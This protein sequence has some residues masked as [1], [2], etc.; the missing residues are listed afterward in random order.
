VLDRFDPIIFWSN[1]ALEAH[2]RD[3]TFDG[4][5]RRDE[6]GK[7]RTEL[8]PV[9]GGPT[10]TSRAFAIIHLAMY[11]AMFRVDPDAFRAKHSAFAELACYQA[12]LPSAP[13][14]ASKAAAVAGAA[15]VTIRILFNDNLVEEMLTRFRLHLLENGSTKKAVEDGLDFGAL[16]GRQLLDS[17]ANDGSEK[18]DARYRPWGL[19]GTFLRDPMSAGPEVGVTW[20]EDVA[21]FGASPKSSFSFVGPT[22]ALG[23]VTTAPLEGLGE[24]LKAP[25]W[26]G[27]LAE[28]LQKGAAQGSAALTREP[29]E[30]VIGIFWGYDGAVGLGVP[31]RLYNQCLHAIIDQEK[32]DSETAAVLLALANLAMADAGVLAWLEKYTYHV[33]RPAT[34]VRMAE[35]GFKPRSTSSPTFAAGTLS[36]PPGGAAPASYNAV[37]T[38]LATLPSSPSVD[39]SD[40]GWRPLG[41]PQ[42]NSS[43]RGS[44]GASSRTPQFPAY[45]SGHATFGAVAFGVASVVLKA[46]KNKEDTVFSF[47][48]DEYNGTSI[49]ADGSVR[50][51]H[52]RNMTLAQAIH[53]NAVSRIYLGVHWRMDAVEGVR[54]GRTI[55]E[56]LFANPVGPSRLAAPKTA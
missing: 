20:G 5:G 44:I 12:S 3:F 14:G 31:P 2:R 39:D 51:A 38:W 50:P 1:V 25:G 21:L 43:L 10:R 32:L 49:D 22:E 47:L 11:D 48:S 54:L 28:V 9:Q 37:K 4:G 7:K 55:V 35:E 45:P 30:T 16:V 34:L 40:P 56:S 41:A 19:P 42:T 36:M 17:R 29:E 8:K 23:G 24:F 53:E 33:A 27:E 52:S 26:N 15:A 46:I 13:A 18:E 6:A